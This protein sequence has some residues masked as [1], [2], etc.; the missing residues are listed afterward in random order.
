MDAQVSMAAKAALRICDSSSVPRAPAL[1][2]V[3]RAISQ[4]PSLTIQPDLS[5]VDLI[6]NIKSARKEISAS[7]KEVFKCIHCA[8]YFLPKSK[9]DAL[10]LEEIL[11]SFHCMIFTS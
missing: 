6:K 8:K 11:A 3:S 2:Y 10:K 9:N 4:D 1:L 5:A 7:E